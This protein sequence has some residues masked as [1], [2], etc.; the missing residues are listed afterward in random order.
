MQ[1]DI[2]RRKHGLKVLAKVKR[3]QLSELSRREPFDQRKAR[4]NEQRYVA[5]LKAQR[6]LCQSPSA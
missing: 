2:E 6:E 4:E 1:T 3:Q 5:W